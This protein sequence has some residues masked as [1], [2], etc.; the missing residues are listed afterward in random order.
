MAQSFP[1]VEVGN[2]NT[3]VLFLAKVV[4]WDD[5]NN[6]APMPTQDQKSIKKIFKNIFA[7]KRITTNDI[8]T[9]IH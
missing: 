3:D 4:P 9:V 5:D 7:T 6:F 1:S 8:S 2:T